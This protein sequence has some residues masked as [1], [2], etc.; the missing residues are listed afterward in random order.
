[1]TDHEFVEPG[2]LAV[3]DRCAVTVTASVEGI[4]SRVWEDEGD[5][6]VALRTPGRGERV[7]HL[8]QLGNAVLVSQGNDVPERVGR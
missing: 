2:K 8:N 1:M 7:F 3:G 5:R 4:V 6:W